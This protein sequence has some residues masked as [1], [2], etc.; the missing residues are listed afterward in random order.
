MPIVLKSGSLNLLEPSG[1]IQA[2]NGIALLF[3]PLSMER[4]C[5]S[6]VMCRKAHKQPILV[7]RCHQKASVIT[8]NTATLKLC[9]YKIQCCFNHIFTLCA[10]GRAKYRLRVGG[11]GVR[12]RQ[13]Q[14]I[15]PS[16]KRA[17][18]LWGPPSFL[19]NGQSG[20]VVNL[21]IRL[22]LAP[23]L[24]K[25]TLLRTGTRFTACQYVT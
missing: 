19:F 5:E 3:L 11:S 2:C 14:Q 7:A 25:T 12:I 1:S 4:M 8:K 24:A 17:A 23:T 9:R 13:E 18:Q 20:R 16:L 6:A 22:H 10:V 21:T 15:L